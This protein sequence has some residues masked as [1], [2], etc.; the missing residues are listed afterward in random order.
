MEA[1]AATLPVIARTRARRPPPANQRQ[2]SAVCLPR[3][4]HRRRLCDLTQRAA[5]R[6]ASPRSLAP[7]L[8]FIP[9]STSSPQP[10]SP[11]LFLSTSQGQGTRPPFE[12]S[13][14]GKATAAAPRAR[15][16]AVC[17]ISSTFL[18]FQATAVAWPVERRRLPVTQEW[19]TPLRRFRGRTTLNRRG[20]ERSTNWSPSRNARR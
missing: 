2:M 6:W 1:C 3:R 5:G 10:P 11:P 20:K 7:V 9:P 14:P 12:P 16:S 13:R 4:G 18:S 15:T 19:S 17:P 8:F